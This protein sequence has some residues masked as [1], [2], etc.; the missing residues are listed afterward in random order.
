MTPEE[1]ARLIKHTAKEYQIE[2]DINRGLP[3]LYVGPKSPSRAW[4]ESTLEDRDE[5]STFFTQG[6]DAADLLTDAEQAAEKF[7]VT[8]KQALIWILDSAGALDENLKHR[9]RGDQQHA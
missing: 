8:E 4:F 1:M 3:Y 2:V 7:N 9:H 5:P 6:D